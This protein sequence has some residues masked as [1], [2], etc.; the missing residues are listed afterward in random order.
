MRKE[1]PPPCEALYA[2]PHKFPKPTALPAAASIKPNR[3]FHCSL[4]VDTFF[5]INKNKLVDL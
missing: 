2:K 5:K 3:V 4:F 1:A